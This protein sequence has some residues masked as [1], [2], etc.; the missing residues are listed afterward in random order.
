LIKS[1]APA[2]FAAAAALA[3]TASA[4]PPPPGPP[5][6]HGGSCFWE[7]DV[8]N[9]AARDDHTVYLRVGGRQV[10]ELKMFGN[11]FDLSWLHHIGLRTFGSSNVC[12]GGGAGLELETRDIAAGHQR[13]PVTSIRKLSPD[14]IAALPKD[15]QP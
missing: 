3:L 7:R 15:A 13:C 8:T 12:E 6:H 5:P 4:D 10:Y 9:F 11:C 14:E 2:A 1:L